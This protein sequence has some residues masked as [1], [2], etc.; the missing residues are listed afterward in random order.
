M[1]TNLESWRG[2]VLAGLM[3][4]AGAGGFL[5][6]GG[7]AGA[8]LFAFGLTGVVLSG[9]P[10]Y[11]GRAGTG[12]GWRELAAILAGNI[13]GAAAAGLMARACAYPEA[14][15]RAADIVAGRLE[16]GP[17]KALW[18]AAG[19]G[20]VID[21]T[22][23]LYREKGK[24]IAAVLLGVPLFIASGYYHSIADVTYIA[25]AWRWDAGLLWYYPVIVI[26]NYLGCNVRRLL[27]E[28]GTGKDKRKAAD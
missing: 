1:E 13:L 8:V 16:A 27:L 23:W 9:A 2:R 17:W 4:G 26:G 25:A 7:L 12:T 6:Q 3:I 18:R 11:T 22:V 20:L 19:C 14:L 24:S 21:L 15:A 28:A 5:A 10:L